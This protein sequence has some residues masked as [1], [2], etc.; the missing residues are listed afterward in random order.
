MP[1]FDRTGPEGQGSR[2]GRQMGKCSTKDTSETGQEP[3]MGR[4][5]GRGMGRGVGRAAGR[6]A[7][8]G[9][10]RGAGRGTGRNAG[11]KD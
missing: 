4:G 10:G 2:T 11:Q 5:P 6:A 8:R 7:N 1:G 3:F 9:G